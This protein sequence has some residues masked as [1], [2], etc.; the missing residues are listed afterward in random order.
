MATN[1]YNLG[2]KVYESK[3]A[4]EVLDEE[5]TEFLPRTRSVQEFFELYNSRFYNI[6]RNTHEYFIKHSLNYLKNWI[7]PRIRTKQG[8]EQQINELQHQIDSIEKSHPILPNNSI[9]SPNP[10]NEWES[11]DD[12]DLYYMQS[13]QKRK[14]K[15]SELYNQ[16][17]DFHQKT[18]MLDRDFIIEVDEDVIN[19]I[20]SGKGIETTEDIF[21]SNFDINTYNQNTEG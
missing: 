19:D 21:D 2:K 9:I 1:N 20:K 14:I 11:L 13:N 16:I 3:K 8:L 7:N 10:S 6:L 4:R 17:K 12:I 15:N 5:F 18:L